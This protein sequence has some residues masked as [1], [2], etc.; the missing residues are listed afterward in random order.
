M[1]GR[2]WFEVG[3]KPTIDVSNSRQKVTILRAVTHEGESFEVW[4]EE[5]LTAD[6]G[7][8]LLDA[9]VDRFGEELVVFL[10]RASYF[11][12]TDVWGFVSD[13]EETEFV[14]DT[15]VERV[16]GEK[17]TVWYFPPR[18]PELNPVEHCWK[19]VGTWY[20]YRLIEDL[21]ELKQS[22]S[23]ALSQID[24]PNLFNYLCP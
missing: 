2:G 19:Q 23:R 18:L 11:Y 1:S 9:L 24:E 16:R 4:T 6:H 13:T 3:S 5:N 20:K 12:A 7:V 17:L 8:R 14:G 10:D 15:S 21:K 22:L